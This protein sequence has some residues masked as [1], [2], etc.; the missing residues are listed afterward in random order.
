MQPRPTARSRV[1]ALALGVGPA[2][3]LATLLGA[4]PVQA[5]DSLSRS[6]FADESEALWPIEVSMQIVPV[7][8]GDE[9]AEASSITVDDG[10]STRL[11]TV[12]RAP[13]GQH[14]FELEVV[15]R[16][17]ARHRVELEYDLTVHE[18]RYEQ[19]SPSSYLWHRLE[20]GPGPTLGPARVRAVRSDIVSLHGGSHV[21]SVTI[22]RRQYEV[23][24]SA[25]STRP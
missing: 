10:H 5:S 18:A 7:A 11:A 12:Q 17:H 15:A 4:S 2:L 19:M 9:F 22:G 1:L 21:E 3:G 8:L 13:T 6:I 25:A 24:L 20:F 16:H 23:R 14:T